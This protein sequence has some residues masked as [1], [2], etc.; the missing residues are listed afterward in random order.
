MG[1]RFYYT[2]QVD[3]ARINQST[4]HSLSGDILFG[5]GGNLDMASPENEGEGYDGTGSGTENWKPSREAESFYITFDD[6]GLAEVTWI[7]PCIVEENEAEEFFCFRFQIFCRS[8]RNSIT[9]SVYSRD[10]LR[11]R[12]GGFRDHSDRS[13]L[14]TA[15]SKPKTKTEKRK[16]SRLSRSG[17]LSVLTAVRRRNSC[18]QMP[19]DLWVQC[20]LRQERTD[21]LLT[22]NANDGTIVDWGNEL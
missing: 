1:W 14:D 9:K 7:N 15:G 21:S 8:F 5:L 10:A 19:D 3:E 6:E 22:I 17:I 4:D 16:K 20:Y 11:Q 12:S 13:G 2:R 18:W